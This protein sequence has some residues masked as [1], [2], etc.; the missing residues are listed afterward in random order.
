MTSYQK[1]KAENLKL[2]QDIHTLVMLDESK[3]PR[4]VLN[5]FAVKT[6]WKL[7]F[8]L[9][10]FVWGSHA[11]KSVTGHSDGLISLIKDDHKK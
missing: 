10:N 3:E 11:S 8:K 1:L 7:R 4:D 2:K 9:E 6:N 5:V